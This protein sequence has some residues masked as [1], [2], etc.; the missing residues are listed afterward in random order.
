VIELADS[1]ATLVRYQAFA[2]WGL[3]LVGQAI[4]LR[5]I[6]AGPRLHYQ[7]YK[8]LSRTPDENL[9]L[10]LVL[11]QGIIVLSAL[12]RRWSSIRTVAARL[13]RPWQLLLLGAVFVLPAAAVSADPAFMALEFLFASFMQALNLA[14]VVLAIAALPDE[15]L[16]SFRQRRMDALLGVAESTAC[17]QSAPRVDRFALSIAA[18]V[19]L[20]A[21]LL[22]VFSYQR[23]PH[24]TDEV[25]YILH[26]R[27]LASGALTLPAP[28][29]PEAFTFY[30]MES[31]DS[32][33]Y[34]STPP[35]WPAL[36]AVGVRLG[37]PWLVN[38]LLGGVNILLA[39]LL[40]WGLYQRRTARI[41]LLLL[42]ASPWFVFMAMNFMTHSFSLT[43]ALAA[44]VLVLQARRTGAVHWAALAGVMLGIGSLIR[45]LDGLIVAALMGLW[46]LGLG[47][48]RLTV[49]AIVALGVGTLLTG[50]LVLPYN[51][52]LTGDALSFPLN[53]YVDTHFGAGRNGFGFG[54]EKG[55]GWALDP[56]PGHS[57]MDALINANLNGHSLNT[58]LFG[59][60]TGSLLLAAIAIVAGRLPRSDRLM[61]VVM[62]VVFAAYFF[63]Y[64]SG[65]PDFGAR[66]WYTM[67]IPLVVLTVKG[68]RTLAD[69]LSTL[70]VTQA[71]SRV[72][73]AVGLLALLALV[74]YF[75]WRATDKYYH[76]WGMRPDVRELAAKYDFGRSLVLIRGKSHPDYTSAAVYNPLDLNADA[77][78]YAWAPDA[79]V[80]SA[81]LA[82]YP[83]RPV[84]T[85]DGPTITGR[86]YEIAERP[87]ATGP[88][89]PAP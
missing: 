39:Y 27:F 55:F 63:Y 23:H 67:L 12:V 22:A 75:P 56:N 86:G 15:W 5:L 43:C 79:Q 1:R 31:S 81:L 29:V 58:E 68:M 65:G 7:H 32:R 35:G 89:S 47:G 18:W 87:A 17:G 74:N 42:A 25:A 36:L 46:A 30:L 9:L 21:A 73:A 41:A 69:R 14:T 20:V 54:P 19:V 64:Y 61:V 51:Y 44:A 82:A 57:P 38:P 78:V 37:V 83:D 11:V 49:P 62:L 26:A 60:S 10:A 16:V 2:W 80:R 40:I 13:F 48:R 85:L 24:I 34:A 50:A 8:L 66:Y 28:P 84:W 59:W 72:L 6:D 70:G 53:A 4:S 52:A 76:F 88:E 45:P 71:E 33:W 77:P 3:A